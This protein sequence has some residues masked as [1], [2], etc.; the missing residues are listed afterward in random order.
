ML[1]ALGAS[2]HGGLAVVMAVSIAAL[3]MLAAGGVEMAELFSERTKMK[4][5]ADAAALWGA[6]ELTMSTQPGV[7]A[8]AEAFAQKE[9]TMLPA[10]TTITVKA[11]VVAAPDRKKALKVSIHGNR[12]SY[13]GSLFPPGGFNIDV[14]STALSL[15]KRSLCVLGHGTDNNGAIIQLDN[16]SRVTAPDCMVHANDKLTVAG[17]GQLQAGVTQSVGSASGPITPAA[18]TGAKTIPDPFTGLTVPA[19]A[20]CAGSSQKV[21]YNTPGKIDILPAGVHCS[22]IEVRQGAILQLGK[23][24]HYFSG[25]V[26]LYD[27]STLDGPEATLVFRGKTKFSFGGTSNVTLSGMKTG[28]LAGFVI[29]APNINDSDFTIQSDHVT[30]LLGTLYIPNG[31]L[32]VTGTGKVA[33]T[34]AWTVVVARAIRMQ[35]SPNLYINANYNGSPVPVPN[36]VGPYAGTTRLTH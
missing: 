27:N 18:E 5:V 15:G 36:G 29:Y 30:K 28:V 35:G 10:S 11:E 17:G 21:T 8:R 4:G 1:A 24:I 25:D 20:A 12:P 6:T 16:Q 13:F 32:V 33:E 3:A 23:G 22:P 2:E 9:L 14:S 26:S 34:S 19:G 31:R 7:E